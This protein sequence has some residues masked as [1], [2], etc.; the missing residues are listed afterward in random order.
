MAIEHKIAKDDVGRFETMLR[1]EPAKYWRSPDLQQQFREAIGRREASMPD[2]PASGEPPEAAP[3]AAPA[4][5]GQTTPPGP[6]DGG[7][8]R[9]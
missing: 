3:A 1:D 8:V 9:T 5:P 2:A 7:A 6:A 4:D